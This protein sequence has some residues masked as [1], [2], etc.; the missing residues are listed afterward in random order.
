VAHTICGQPTPYRRGVWFNSAKF[1]NLEYQTYG[2]VPVALAAGEESFYWEHPSGQQCLRINFFAD[3]NYAVT[4][5][6]A[7]GL[8][9]RQEV[10]EQWIRSG[11]TMHSVLANL[12]AANFDPEFFREYEPAVISSFNQQFPRQPVVL[13]R[14]KGLLSRILG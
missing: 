6:N 13:Q 5:F 4:G 2:R 12:G 10:C 9:L 14:R 7:L 8:R 3:R 1:F 11:T